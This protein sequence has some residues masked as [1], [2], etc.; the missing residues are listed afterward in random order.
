MSNNPYIKPRSTSIQGSHEFRSSDFRRP[1]NDSENDNQKPSRSNNEGNLTSPTSTSTKKPGQTVIKTLES[2]TKPELVSIAK[3]MMSEINIK[4][5]IIHDIKSNEKWLSVEL[6][7][8]EG[9]P[10]KSLADSDLKKALQSTK[11]P[12][13]D[14][15][16]I[17]TLLNLKL[18][19]EKS[20][21]KIEEQESSLV[22]LERKRV[23]AIEEAAYLSS[24]LYKKDIKNAQTARIKELEAQLKDNLNEF[25]ELQAKVSQWAKTSKKNQ[26][27]RIV[28]EA[29]QKVLE[30]EAINLQK[31]LKQ[32]VQA[33]RR[34]SAA[35]T[36][37]NS[38]QTKQA[39]NEDVQYH[40][41]ELEENL[42]DAT[43]AYEDL[44][45][46]FE[47]IQ[48]NLKRETTEKEDLMRKCETLQI[49]N[50]SLEN[51]LQ[52]QVEFKSLTR[53]PIALK[54]EPSANSDSNTKR[55]HHD[56]QVLEQKYQEVNFENLILR[57]DNENLR[58]QMDEAKEATKKMQEVF[59]EQE[60]TMH[61]IGALRL[62]NQKLKQLSAKAESRL[63]S[64]QL[65][66]EMLQKHVEMA[67]TKLG[68]LQDAA[69]DLDDIKDELEK[70]KIANQELLAKMREYSDENQMYQEKI[71]ALM[72]NRTRKNNRTSL[73]Y[74]I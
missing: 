44:K 30:E 29:Q 25:T 6:A 55:L 54:N 34:Q 52:S 28:A 48:V 41:N 21:Q 73:V 11:I 56:Y 16:I 70:E 58:K 62:E 42:V 53:P 18:D 66:V 23:A 49:K 57:D 69:D 64:K 2:K 31:R 22:A 46:D 38:G 47:A 67:Q 63:N 33:G 10:K 65:A 20:K 24:I 50:Q 72:Q 59:Q 17:S 27:G 1:S 40:I 15:K 9:K 13:P 12:E 35:N 36:L 4:N 45:A 26:E 71:V 51:Q 43:N 32:A 19:L 39:L 61:T 60:E 14:K 8:F 68:P 37:G 74:F 7:M 5:R 3:K